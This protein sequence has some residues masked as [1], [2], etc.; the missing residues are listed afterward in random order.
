MI[1]SLNCGTWRCLEALDVSWDGVFALVLNV[2]E[3]DAWMDWIEVVGVVFVATNHF[4]AV[5]P[6]LPTVDG[7]CPWSGRSA[8]THQ[9]LKSQRSAITAIVHLMRLQMSDKVVADGSVVHLGRSARTLKMHFTKPVT[10]RF[11]WFYNG[12]T[13]RAWGRT[14][15]AWSRTILTSPSESP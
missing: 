4:L 1:T 6:F 10:F 9:R 8:P 15:R 7:L 14:V 13:V 12:R 5:A 3:W 11:F 2:S